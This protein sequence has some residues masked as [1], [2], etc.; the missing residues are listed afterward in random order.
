M[1]ISYGNDRGKEGVWGRKTQLIIVRGQFRGNSTE[2]PLDIRRC[3]NC[4]AIDDVKTWMRR[5]ADLMREVELLRARADAIRSRAASPPTSAVDG[6]PRGPGFEG[7]RLGGVIGVADALER[8]AAGKVARAAEIYQE[9]DAV[10]EQ[11]KGKHA[12]ER[13]FTSQCRYL[14]LMDWPD[15]IFLLFGDKDDF[16]DREDS[17]IRRTYS[18]HKAAL[19]DIGEILD[20]NKG[21]KEDG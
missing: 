20:K 8:Q 1:V 3:H 12:A 15:V 19:Q 11:I 18:I 2:F 10:I 4:V 14:D 9:I 13:K 17:Y 7:D 6:M 16:G 21:E 5:Y